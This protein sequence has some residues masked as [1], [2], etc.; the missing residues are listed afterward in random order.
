MAVVSPDL[1]A[2]G[3]L[4]QHQTDR[5]GEGRDRM[6]REFAVTAIMAASGCLAINGDEIRPLRPHFLHPGVETGGVQRGIDPVH[7]QGE[8][9]SAGNAVVIGGNIAQERQMHLAPGP[10]VP[11]V[12]A[13]FGALYI[14]ASGLAGTWLQSSPGIG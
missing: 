13:G 3:L 5:G 9:M 10:A 8:L 11:V 6:K 7:Q 2:N 14:G 1:S 12:I 4:P